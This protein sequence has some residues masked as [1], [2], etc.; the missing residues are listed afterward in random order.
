M[1]RSLSLEIATEPQKTSTALMDDLDIAKIAMQIQHEKN[2]K[3]DGA[4]IA[5]GYFHIEMAFFKVLVKKIAQ[6]GGPYILKQCGISIKSLISG[7][8][9]NK[10]KRMHEVLAAAFEVLHFERFSDKEEAVEEIIDLVKLKINII[11]KNRHN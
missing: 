3:Y 4:F 7:L 1:R 2:Q 9:Y 10:C 6:S 11:N 5:L 8:S